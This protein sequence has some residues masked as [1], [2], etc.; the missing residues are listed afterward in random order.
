MTVS[1]S[2][3]SPRVLIVGVKWP[4]ETFLARLIRGL[5][6]RGVP[7]S[8]VV[9]ARPTA[10]WRQLAN[11]DFLMAPGW[12]GSAVGRLARTGGQLAAASL[13]SLPETR[14]VFR[15]ERERESTTSFI[16]RFSRL[17]PFV[18]RDW[19]IVYFPWNAAAILYHSLM[20][21]MPSVISCRGAQINIGPHDPK[22]SWLREGLEPTFRKAA[23]VHC[24]SA[25]IRDEAMQYGLDP[26]KA[27][28]IRPAVDPD[29][30]RPAAR[31]DEDAGVFRLVST[32]SIIWRKGYEYALVAV[33]QLVD[34]G[35]P[36]RF[37]MIGSGPEFQRLLYTIRDLALDD[38]VFLHGRL[39]PTAVVAQLQAADVFLLSSLSEGI[40]NA[41][42]EGMACGLPVVTTAVGGMTEAV[43]D[44]VEGFVVPSR[45]A[46][47]MAE[48]L[49]DLWRNRELR[50]R[51]GAA[52]RA[53]VLADFR[54]SKQADAFV[55]L[56]RSVA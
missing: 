41:V 2:F 18:N 19:D 14:R 48:A 43:D 52:G 23:A 35:V 17:L 55:A 22:R 46:T 39:S 25:A 24:V 6:A 21:G 3:S 51:M 1:A 54:L 31:Q 38:H 7:V 28:I 8:I 16:A 40:S 53:R 49:L 32:G 33:R 4:P 56:F 20:D 30:F 45:D 27:V 15:L 5:A 37:D 11:I 47:A 26:A 10:E 29:V 34:H 50:R 44:G 9:A 42:L 36:V 12:D 13:R